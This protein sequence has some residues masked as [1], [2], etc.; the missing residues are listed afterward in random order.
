M[1][2]DTAGQ[3]NH[4]GF[5]LEIG[6]QRRRRRQVTKL[7]FARHQAAH[8]AL[9]AAHDRRPVDIEAMLAEQSGFPSYHHR[10]GPLA[11]RGEAR[12]DFD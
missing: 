1:L 5:A 2:I 9:G 10:P 3:E 7:N 12:F 8:H 11:D 4:I 6:T